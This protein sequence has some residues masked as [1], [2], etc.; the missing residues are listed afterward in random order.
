ML[1]G[2]RA[3]VVK[4]CPLWAVAVPRGVARDRGDEVGLRDQPL[5][6]DLASTSEIHGMGVTLSAG[7]DAPRMTPRPP[8]D[9]NFP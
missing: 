3:E 1:A 8:L 9:H 6:V 5:C 7:S 4:C 2:R